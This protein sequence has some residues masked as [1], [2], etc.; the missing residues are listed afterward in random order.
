MR[1][2]L[3]LALVLGLG[4]PASHAA[5]EQPD[6]R[7]DVDNAKVN[8]C[9]TPGDRCDDM[10]RSAI[11]GAKREI[12]VQAMYFTSRKL[13]RGLARA[14]ARGVD[15]RIIMSIGSEK[16][17]SKSL[18]YF[19]EKGIPVL[20]DATVKTQHNKIMII[21]RGEV[22][23]GSYNFTSAAQN[24]NAEN[25]I[26]ITSAPEVVGSFTENWKRRAAASRPAN[27]GA[28]ASGKNGV[29]EDDDQQ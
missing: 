7:M 23:T 13:M 17:R 29:E 1:K 14:K 10:L 3:L 27:L 9:F 4:L 16:R 12:L 2:T 22:F 25:M 28:A 5:S 6:A 21:D 20:I 15:V 8:A 18:A 26:R 11:D 24:K 19:L